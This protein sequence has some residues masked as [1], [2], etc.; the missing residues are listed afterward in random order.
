M[1]LW[2][3]ISFVWPHLA[4]RSKMPLPYGSQQTHEV[5][6][7]CIPASDSPDSCH[8]YCFLISQGPKSNTLYT[9]ASLVCLSKV[10]YIDLRLS[11]GLSH[12]FLG[13]EDITG[14]PEHQQLSQK[15]LSLSP[16]FCIAWREVV[17]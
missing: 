16:N 17:S 12:L 11:T 4:T 7:L 1:T 13:S 9:P 10:P 2:G 8:S 14:F 15:I 3:Q 6:A 5:A